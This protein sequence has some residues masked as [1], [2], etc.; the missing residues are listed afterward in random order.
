[1]ETTDLQN[2]DDGWV[3]LLEIVKHHQDVGVRRKASPENE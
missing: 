2:W 1:M 3:A